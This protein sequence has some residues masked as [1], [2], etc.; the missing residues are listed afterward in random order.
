V[1]RRVHTDPVHA[2]GGGRTIALAMIV[3]A[4]VACDGAPEVQ[5]AKPAPEPASGE[6]PWPAPAD[7]LD[8]AVAAGLE[9]TTHEFLD[10]HVH[11]H[12]DVFVNGS[13]V[14]VPAGIGINIEDPAVHTVEDELGTTYGGIDPPCAQPCISPLHTHGTD[15]I[16]HTESAV[17]QSNTLGQFFTEWGVELTDT[18]VGGYCS[19]GA[20]IQ[21]FVN[22]APNDGDPA[23]IQL[24][25]RLEIAIVIGSPPEEVPST[26]PEA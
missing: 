19:P 25:D 8:L 4:L 23:Q 24:M 14:E 3:V 22:G 17:D 9:P 5:D 15:G 10:F 6:I 21:V 18:C 13:P 26:F 16:L 1:D 12:L 11:A 7:P 2:L 20:S